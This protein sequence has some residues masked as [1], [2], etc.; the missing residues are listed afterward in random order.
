MKK[1]T[2]VSWKL[3]TGN[4]GGEG[5][6]ITDEEDGHVSVRVEKKW[7]DGQTWSDEEKYVIHC[8]VTWLTPLDT[9]N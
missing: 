4:G 9:S 7:R 1:S 3:A 5:T 6:V 2:R 8:A